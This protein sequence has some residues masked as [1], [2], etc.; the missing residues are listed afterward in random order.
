MKIMCF[1]KK[2]LFLFLL[3]P[4]LIL[5]VLVLPAED[6]DSAVEEDPV[7]E[8]FFPK[9][10]PSQGET[11]NAI[12]MDQTGPRL[13]DAEPSNAVPIISPETVKQVVASDLDM[14]M[15]WLQMEH[16]HF[17][18][19]L[20]GILG[21]VV[22]GLSLGWLLQRILHL[23]ALGRPGFSR[24]L[25]ITLIGPVMM[26]LVLIGIFFAMVPVVRTIHDAYRWDLRIF[27][28]LIA[29]TTA[30]GI[31]HI[32]E[33]F[34]AKISCLVVRNANNL[35]V[36]IVDLVKKVLMVAVLML[37]I[38]FVLQN[39]YDINLSS[40]LTGAGILGLAVAFSAKDVLA[41]FFGSIVIFLDKPF[42]IG[43]RIQIDDCNGIVEKVGMR[44][45]RIFTE[46]E[47]II[48]IPNSMF[49]AKHVLNINH[50]GLLK[51]LF[52]VTM[53]YSSTPDQMRQTIQLLH[54]IVD[55]FHGTDLPELKPHIFFDEL[56]DWSMNI[57]VIMWLKTNK[58]EE[59]EKYVDEINFALIEGLA[60]AGLS[61]SFPTS[62][63]YLC[64]SDGGP[65]KVILSQEKGH[66]SEPRS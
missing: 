24:K 3:F 52:E 35:D 20:L 28:T 2:G 12:V 23:H 1:S 50:R 13:R 58:F 15:K 60:K 22:I 40:M 30:W 45:T 59:K 55:D 8:A 26:L 9:K 48:T 19:M 37:T 51:Y 41:N 5:S 27:F 36:E 32:L 39:V 65:V 44:S 29:A 16:R 4:C 62:S 64:G 14:T 17:V 25:T 33:V 11:E 42:K 61:M 21:A 38:A 57:K 54:S 46:E 66:P 7:L 56:D 49:A 6:A 34:S 43:D 18:M 10:K 53:S 47:G 31:F 63:N